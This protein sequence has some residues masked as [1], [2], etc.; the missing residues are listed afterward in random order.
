MTIEEKLSLIRGFIENWDK[1]TPDEMTLRFYG[2]PRLIFN[3]RDAFAEMCGKLMQ[4]FVCILKVL[5][6]E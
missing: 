3:K 2:D 4:T 1:I 5:D 6:S